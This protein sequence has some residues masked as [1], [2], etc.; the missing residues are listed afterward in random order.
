MNFTF[1]QLEAFLFSVRL[2][3][4]SAAAVKLHTTQSAISKRLAELE[5]ALGGPLLHRTTHGLELTQ[6]GRELLPLAEEAQRLWRRIA[7]DISVDKT[8]RGTFRVGVTE[9]IA[10]T[11]LT[12][13]IQLLQKMHPEVN[14]EP[15]VD[16]GLTLFERLETNKLDL[17][18]MPGAFWGQ[19]FE[20]IKVTQ[21]EQVWIASPR[22]QIPARA[23]KPH[24][25]ADYPVIEQP[26]GASKNRFYEAWRAEH[27]FRFGKVMLTNSTTVLRELT[28]SG[29]GLSQQAL[30]YVRPDIR[31]GL[32][33]VVK[34]D[35]MPPPLVYSAVY[36]RD[37]VSPALARIV[38]L[39]V[40][41]CDFTVRASQH[42]VTPARALQRRRN[43]TRAKKPTRQT[44]G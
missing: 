8:L 27:G 43:A 19:A 3:S 38:E 2:Q 41:T 26:A 44:R 36:R 23:L 10:M 18:I 40:K 22:L 20:S 15:V 14:I 9:L 42:D 39:A 34:S 29:F 1:K 31:S 12:R 24:E 11:W 5:V 6:V 16:A 32:L 4:F 7:H 25:F 17:A 35:P 28:I 21:V 37:N 30:D 33:R 13:L